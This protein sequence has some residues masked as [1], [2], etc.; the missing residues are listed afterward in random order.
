[1][2]VNNGGGRDNGSRTNTWPGSGL[3]TV[4]CKAW[5]RI[6]CRQMYSTDFLL[7]SLALRP[8]EKNDHQREFL[9]FSFLQFNAELY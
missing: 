1:M 2:N 8:G 3:S 5:Y 9:R 7:E 6:L 4:E